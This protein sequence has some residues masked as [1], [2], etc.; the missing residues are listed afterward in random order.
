MEFAE[1]SLWLDTMGKSLTA[2]WFGL[3]LRRGNSLIGARRSVLPMIA[4]NEK[5]W[6]QPTPVDKPLSGL[7][8]D[9]HGAV[10]HF[11]VPA[12]GWG[13]TVDAKEAKE[14]APEALE[15][16]KEWRKSLRPKPKKT[17]HQ[18]TV[19]ARAP[20]RGALAAGAAPAADRRGSGA[21]AGSTYG[22]LTICPPV[23][24]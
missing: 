23:V 7:G 2:P 15:R 1:I 11:L 17:Q 12:D 10:H 6:L 24:K 14:L 16:A 13:S 20:G 5:G 22:V 21:S 3:H 9:M 18:R 8:E 4:L 19:G